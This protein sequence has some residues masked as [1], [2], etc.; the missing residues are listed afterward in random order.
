MKKKEI[1][2]I[3]KKFKI[4]GKSKLLNRAIEIAIQIAP[5]EINVLIMGENGSGKE[6]FS[7]IIHMLSCYKNGKFIK[8]NCSAI[9]KGTVNSELF[10]H[11]KGSFTGAI[12][13][14]KGYFEEAQNG[15]IFLDE[16]GEMPLNTQ[17]K[18]LRVIE[19]KEFI[20]VGSS[21]VQKIN[22]RIIS[23]TNKNLINCVKKLKFRED[24]YYRIN[25][26]PIYVPSLQEREDDI[27]LLIKKFAVDF[28]KKYQI[29]PIN[30]SKKAEKLILK[31][32]FPGNIRQL[33]NFIE[34][35]SVL[36]INKKI[37]INKINK[38]LPKLKNDTKNK[39]KKYSK[40]KMYIISTYE[41]NFLYKVLFE[42]KK[43]VNEL[44]KLYFNIFK[45]KI[46]K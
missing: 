36:E 29:K 19:Y 13:S 41:K 40:K 43:D 18:L 45:K 35:I 34:Y 25:T 39:I 7:K 17:S 27:I 21:K 10:G 46:L 24:L 3:K 4:I 22:L 31:Y 32:R 37:S 42:I 5:T 8:V 9:P 20:K 1:E 2:K 16:I 33:K 30:L 44:K 23:A 28:S 12:K 14:R 38:Y 6:S 26:I 15:T 11:E